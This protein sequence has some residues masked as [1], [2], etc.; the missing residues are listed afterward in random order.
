MKILGIVLIAGGILMLIFRG[1]S[2]TQEKNIIDAGPIEL[3]SKEKKNVSWPMYAG[4]IAVAAGVMVL[5]A[6]RKKI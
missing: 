1:F 2:F 5:L 3:N 6:S 4:G